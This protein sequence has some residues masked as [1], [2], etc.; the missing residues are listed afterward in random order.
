MVESLG[1]FIHGIISSANKDTF[2]SSFTAWIS[3]I[4]PSCLPVLAKTSSSDLNRS[5]RNG[6]SCLVPDFGGNA[7]SFSF[8]DDLGC[9]LT[10]YCYC[11]IDICSMSS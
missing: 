9:G 3:F 8:N 5:G 11:Y 7:L 2:T 6:Y 4:S 10:V 1:S